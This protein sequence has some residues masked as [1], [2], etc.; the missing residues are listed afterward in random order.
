MQTISYQDRPVHEQN[1]Q[2]EVPTLQLE[3]PFLYHAQPLPGIASHH[4][5]LHPHRI[6][7]YSENSSYLSVEAITNNA[8]SYDDLEAQ[9]SN[10]GQY[11]LS[12]PPDNELMNGGMNFFNEQLDGLIE[13]EPAYSAG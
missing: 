9:P 6:I 1:S 11:L 5:D 3:E 4:D 8:P 10:F 13:D 12:G 7:P 2:P